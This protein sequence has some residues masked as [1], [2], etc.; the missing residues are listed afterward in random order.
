M[1]KNKKP[2]ASD[3][4]K[5]IHISFEIRPTTGTRRRA[6]YSV[7]GFY[8]ISLNRDLDIDKIVYLVF[9]YI[10]YYHLVYILSNIYT[11]T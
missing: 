4:P 1:H 9:I 8:T 10:L 2:A 11:N 7:V 5:T 6:F 3:S